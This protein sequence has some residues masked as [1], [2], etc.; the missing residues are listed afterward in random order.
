MSSPASNPAPVPRWKRI[1]F[2]DLGLPGRIVGGA[3]NALGW[4][5]PLIVLVEVLHLQAKS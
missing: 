3:A 5:I 1:L 2:A 4:L